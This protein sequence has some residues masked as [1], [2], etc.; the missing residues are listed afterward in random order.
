V[1]AIAIPQNPRCI[2]VLN[3]PAIRGFSGTAQDER[4]GEGEIA[5]RDLREGGNYFLKREKNSYDDFEAFR[6]VFRG[7]LFPTGRVA[8]FCLVVPRLVVV[9]FVM[10]TIL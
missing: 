8:F 5:A 6:G 9:L 10:M 4:D 7:S 2:R 1:V 3:R